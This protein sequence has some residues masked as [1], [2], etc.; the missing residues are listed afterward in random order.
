MVMSSGLTATYFAGDLAVFPA[1]HTGLDV[2]NSILHMGY[3]DPT[4]FYTASPYI[5]AI[6]STRIKNN[7]INNK[8]EYPFIARDMVASRVNITLKRDPE[9]FLGTVPPPFSSS[10]LPLDKVAPAFT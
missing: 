9:K 10:V 3:V 5:L 7:L 4:R 6:G 2:D 1:L 8:Q